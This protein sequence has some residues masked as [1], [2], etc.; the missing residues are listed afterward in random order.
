VHR[1]WVH[2]CAAPSVIWQQN[3]PTYAQK[4]QSKNLEKVGASLVPS[5]CENFGAENLRHNGHCSSQG[6]L[7][8]ERLQARMR[9]KNTNFARHPHFG[10]KSSTNIFQTQKFLPHS[11]R[12]LSKS[13]LLFLVHFTKSIQ[14][15][16]G[17][18]ACRGVGV[19]ANK[20]TGDGNC[21]HGL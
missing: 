15:R 7:G 20:G 16:K 1:P 8:R 2:V 4:C 3:T 5:P 18:A 10:Q 21:V 14:K 12:H 6:C 19:V 13:G 9:T 17:S 11:H